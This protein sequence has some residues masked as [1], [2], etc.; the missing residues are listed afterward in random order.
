M[1]PHLLIK[2]AAQISY[3]R[4][5]ELSGGGRDRSNKGCSTEGQEGH[6]LHP[7]CPTNCAVYTTQ[8]LQPAQTADA[9]QSLD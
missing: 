8:S 7:Y 6:C 3:M 4:A 1:I 5:A 9:V 2:V